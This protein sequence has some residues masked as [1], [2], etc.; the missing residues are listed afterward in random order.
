M[1]IGIDAD[2]GGNEARFVNDYRGVREK[3]NAEFREVWDEREGRRGI[4]V[5]VLP[6]GKGKK[7]R[8]IGKGEEICVSYGRG[9]WG[10]RRGAGE[11]ED[12]VEK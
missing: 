9:F 5:W 8:G 11:G 4:G 10:A 2:K 6:E 1:G 7:V 3:P 12:V